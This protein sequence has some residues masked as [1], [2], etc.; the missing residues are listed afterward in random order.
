MAFTPINTQEEFDA[1]ISERLKR[2][3]D[4][5]EKQYSDYDALKGRAGLA[6]SLQKQLE[7]ANAQ[8]VKAQADLGVANAQLGTVNELTARAAAAERANLQ[9]KIAADVGIPLELAGR[10]A[11]EDEAAMRADAESIMPLLA[12]SR[13]TQPLF[14]PDEHDGE[15]ASPYSELLHQMSE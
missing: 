9:Y 4:K 7:Q 12:R 10:L 8:L 3:R 14:K 1:A 6:D 5:L 15:G 2:E 13:E 11:G